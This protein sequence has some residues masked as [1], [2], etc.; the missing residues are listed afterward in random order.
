[1]SAEPQGVVAL[2]ELMEDE[3]TGREPWQA[4]VESTEPVAMITAPP[5]SSTA[6]EA[7]IQP[8]KAFL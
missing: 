8:K 2:I 5:G 7:R 3:E 4:A 1:M 6:T